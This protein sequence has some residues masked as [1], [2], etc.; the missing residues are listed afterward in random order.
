MSITYEFIGV[1]YIVIVLPYMLMMLFIIGYLV[2]RKYKVCVE[3]RSVPLSTVLNI[4]LSKVRLNLKIESV[5]YNFLLVLAVL[6]FTTNVA[7][8]VSRS[9][10]YFSLKFNISTFNELIVDKPEISSHFKESFILYPDF[11][12]Q[13]ILL[14]IMCLFLIVLRRMYLNLPYRKWIIGYTV[15]ILARAVFFLLLIRYH[16]LYYLV[17]MLL[18]P[19]GLI[20]FLVYTNCCRKFYLLLKGRREEARWHLTQNEYQKRNRVVKQFLYTQ[21]YTYIIY[22]LLLASFLTILILSL[23]S[24]FLNISTSPNNILSHAITVSTQFRKTLEVIHIFINLVQIIVV[25][26]LEVVLAFSYLM[27]CIGI[28]WKLIRRQKKYN[29]VNDWVT[30]PLMERY[31]STLD[32]FSG[33]R[34]RDLLSIR[35]QPST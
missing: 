35:Q 4:D 29:H 25:I 24:F 27:A 32:N 15:G 7:W 22:F 6:E 13:S 33:N 20:D 30:K 5:I 19:I 8:A 26:L 1:S 14:P 18:F 17:E 28:I 3:I 31:R 2:F 11:I 12:L 34:E 16:D 21:T 23:I 10:I 9:Y